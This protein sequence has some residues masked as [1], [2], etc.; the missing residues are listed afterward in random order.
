MNTIITWEQLSDDE[1]ETMQYLGGYCDW[2][3]VREGTLES[4][5]VKGLAS[6]VED[7]DWYGPSYDITDA[8]RKIMDG[9]TFDWQERS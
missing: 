2:E 6:V 7:D 9:Q 4:L 3:F 5:T 8:G 1:K